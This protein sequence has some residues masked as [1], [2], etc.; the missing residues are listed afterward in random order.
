MNSRLPNSLLAAAI[1]LGTLGGGRAFLMLVLAWYAS[2]AGASNVQSYAPFL[3]QIVV[4]LFV[5]GIAVSL[6]LRARWAWITAMLA[7]GAMLIHE[8]WRSAQSSFINADAPV[9]I[10]ASVAYILALLVVIVFLSTK[11]SREYL[12]TSI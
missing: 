4:G 5:L 7:C 11:G 6:L 8:L 10:I 9:N 12:R 2:R 1:L 3:I